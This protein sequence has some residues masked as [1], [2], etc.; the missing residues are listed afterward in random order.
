MSY[1]NQITDPDRLPRFIIFDHS[2]SAGAL[3]DQTPFISRVNS[4]HCFLV[5]VN[6]FIDIFISQFRRNKIYFLVDE[7]ISG[8]QAAGQLHG[9]FASFSWEVAFWR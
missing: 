9:A 1:A 6:H 2:K 5:G 8:I 4:L 7:E 3:I